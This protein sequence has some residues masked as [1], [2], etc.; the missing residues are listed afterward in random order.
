MDIFIELQSYVL[1][2]ETEESLT[3]EECQKR[4]ED[5]GIKLAACK[6]LCGGITIEEL[7]ELIDDYTTKRTCVRVS[8]IVSF[9]ESPQG[10][11][12][13]LLVGEASSTLFANSYES[14]LEKLSSQ[15][16]VL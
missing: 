7:E 13:M 6:E 15:V 4:E 14:V 5:L 3:C 9:T 2:N 10:R 12:I 16:I 8:D 1:S 11:V